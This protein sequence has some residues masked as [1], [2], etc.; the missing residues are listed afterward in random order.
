VVVW[1]T[2]LPGFTLQQNSDLT[3][4]NWV[5][6]TNVSQ[7]VGNENQVTI[8]PLVGQRFYRLKYP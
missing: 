4:T 7:V 2:N 8:S 6:A 3:T 5:N 1:T